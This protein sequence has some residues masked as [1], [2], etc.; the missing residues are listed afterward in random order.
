MLQKLDAQH[1]FPN[2][3]FIEF[4][5][6]LIPAFFFVL[7]SLSAC[8]ILGSS[9][10]KVRCPKSSNDLEGQVCGLA[11]RL[12]F[13]PADQLVGKEP[14]SDTQ[15]VLV[16]QE[17]IPEVDEASV[18]V[19]LP[20]TLFQLIETSSSS[21]QLMT[22]NNGAFSTSVAPGKYFLCLA[23]APPWA[24]TVNSYGC[25]ALAIKQGDNTKVHVEYTPMGGFFYFQLD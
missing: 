19:T 3:G 1:Q 7:L 22:D 24:P 12:L 8:G 21:M 10:P 17:N 13:G 6:H 16:A 9:E 23:F 2:R 4:R 18:P 14:M 20:A 15:I 25:T 11:L 5:R